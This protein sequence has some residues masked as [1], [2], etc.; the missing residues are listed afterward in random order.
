MHAT[1]PGEIG[2]FSVYQ[3]HAPIISTLV[4]GNIVCYPANSDQ[5]SIPIQNG[6]VEVMDNTIIACIE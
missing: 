4:K 2:S 6:F 3:Q 1:F 5:L